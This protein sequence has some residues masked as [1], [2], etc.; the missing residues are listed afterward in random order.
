MHVI[1][2]CNY[3]Y[4]LKTTFCAQTAHIV[5]IGANGLS[6]FLQ[7]LSLWPLSLQMDAILDFSPAPLKVYVRYN[8]CQ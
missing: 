4:S 5:E 7:H 8:L 6:I 2:L 3:P 1:V